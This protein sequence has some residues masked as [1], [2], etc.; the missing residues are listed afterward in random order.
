[1]GDEKQEWKWPDE[2]RLS[3]P[4]GAT[5]QVWNH[6]WCE[7]LSTPV[8]RAG[9]PTKYYGDYVY[10][11][12]C[13]KKGLNTRLIYQKVECCF[14]VWAVV[15]V[16]VQGSQTS[17]MKSHMETTHKEIW[18]KSAKVP[19]MADFLVRKSQRA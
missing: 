5:S 19:S 2:K 3:K 1:M 8:K 11:R 9:G 15:I 12:E 4:D 18:N 17:S 14:F 13:Q 6:F 16:R 7:K 10:C